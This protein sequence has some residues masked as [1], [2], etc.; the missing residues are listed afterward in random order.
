M[1]QSSPLAPATQQTAVRT[2]QDALR[3]T[4]TSREVSDGRQGDIIEEPARLE[5]TGSRQT[6][7]VTLRATGITITGSNTHA[8]EPRR[9]SKRMLADLEAD[10]AATEITNLV[11]QEGH[12]LTR[13]KHRPPAS[14]QGTE[15]APKDDRD[16]SVVTTYDLDHGSNHKRKDQE[17]DKVATATDVFIPDDYDILEWVIAESQALSREVT[18]PQPLF[19]RDQKERQDGDCGPAAVIRV[20]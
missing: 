19:F 9:T 12:H 8:S 2:E 18:P 5:V 16:L 7:Q 14:G 15:H 4:I 6:P 13:Y 10:R 1:Q 20:L 11:E 17:D 3:I